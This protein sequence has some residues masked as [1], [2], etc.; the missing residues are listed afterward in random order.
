MGMLLILICAMM[1][2]V[3]DI[4]KEKERGTM[5]VLRVSPVKPLVV[6]IARLCR[7]WSW[8]YAFLVGI[9]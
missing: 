1:N 2:Q 8:R 9:R 4:V 3:S 6:L 5:E 7:I